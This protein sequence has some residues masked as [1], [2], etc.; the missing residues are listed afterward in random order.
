MTSCHHAALCFQASSH[1]Y[2]IGHPRANLQE[3]AAGN[4]QEKGT[5]C[6]AEKIKP[7]QTSFPSPLLLPGDE[8]ALDPDCP[9]QSVREWLHEE[10][11]NEVSPERHVIYVVGPPGVQ[12]SVNF[13]SDW[14]NPQEEVEEVTCPDAH[15]VLQYLKAFYHGLP[16]RLLNSPKLSFT[17]WS[18]ETAKRAKSTAKSSSPRF[19][20][21]DTTAECIRIRTRPSGSGIFKRQL[22]LDDLLDA[23]ISILPDD[24]Y[25]LLLLVHHDLYENAEDLFT[26][27]RAYGASRVAVISTARYNPG[28]DHRQNV[29][30]EHVWPASH[31]KAYV[32]AICA[33]EASPTKRPK[34]M[35][36]VQKSSSTKRASRLSPLDS[37]PSAIQ[38]AVSAF[39]AMPSSNPT[40]SRAALAALWLGRVCRTASHELGHC[41]GIDHCV[42]YAC[43]MQGSA[44]L[45]EDA[46]Q[47][48]YLCP[49]DLAKVLHATGADMRERYAVLL[50][51]CEDQRESAMLAAFAAWIQA[52]MR[53]SNEKMEG[54]LHRDEA[55]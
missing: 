7:C 17:S 2:E 8:L 47:P 36:K 46:R 30:R 25:A 50:A 29:E 12:V 9:P 1:A 13:V 39:S 3:H 34:K 51:F 6:S 55:S 20:G 10:N 26:C 52:R 28:L 38:A 33:Q 27:G 49:V 5:C 23:T 40:F 15:N 54:K 22:N 14:T 53:E 37:H 45:A 42:D 16:V 31:C 43:I 32:E 35:S 24:A 44:S 41:F 11:R 18:A 4:S 21:L 48:L 19:I